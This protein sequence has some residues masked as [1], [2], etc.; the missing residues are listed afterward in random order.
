MILTVFDGCHSEE[1]R[2]KRR[3]NVPQKPAVTVR[4]VGPRDGLQMARTIMSS[5]T[6]LSKIT[7]E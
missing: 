3:Q 1:R 6:M 7:G 4:E 5:T 2:S